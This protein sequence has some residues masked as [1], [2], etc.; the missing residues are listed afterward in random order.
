VVK[1]SYL[2]FNDLDFSFCDDGFLWTSIIP[3]QASRLESSLSF[4]EISVLSK[5][6]YSRL[7]E[8]R[9]TNREKRKLAR[10]WSD[11]VLLG[12]QKI[13]SPSVIADPTCMMISNNVLIRGMG[14]YYDDDD[15]EVVGDKIKEGY[16]SLIRLGIRNRACVLEDSSLWRETEFIHSRD[17][18]V[19]YLV[20]KVRSEHSPFL[21]SSV[22]CSHRSDGEVV[23]KNCMALEIP[24]W[25]MAIKRVELRDPNESIG[26][27]TNHRYNLSTP[28]VACAY[29]QSESERR[30][31]MIEQIRYHKRYNQRVREQGVDL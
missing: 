5:A 11:A 4:E 6:S 25:K 9:D 22:L 21:F 1:A 26:R 20:K 15:R 18:N 27:I 19:K 23:C 3:M 30:M 12:L 2:R 14:K 31:R 16:E 10:Y 7:R 13:T 24:L 29:L 17:N 28:T 8:Y